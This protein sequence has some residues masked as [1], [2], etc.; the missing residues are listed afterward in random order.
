LKPDW[1]C[2]RKKAPNPKANVAFASYSPS[3]KKTYALP[4][5]IAECDFII[6]IIIII[7]SK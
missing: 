5:A 7:I 6:I 1:G 4:L 3:T 2:E